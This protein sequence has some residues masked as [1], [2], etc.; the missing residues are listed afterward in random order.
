MDAKKF[1]TLGVDAMSSL[2]LTLS[3]EEQNFCRAIWAHPHLGI[4]AA[5][6][7]GCLLAGEIEVLPQQHIVDGQIQLMREL[8]QLYKVKKEF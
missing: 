1:L 4:W 7:M 5:S 2:Y 8:A 3:R 6:A